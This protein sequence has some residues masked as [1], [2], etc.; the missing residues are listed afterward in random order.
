MISVD[1]RLVSEHSFPAALD[2]SYAVSKW[3]VNNA[4]E[5]FGTRSIVV[6]GESAGA[7]LA[8]MTLIEVRDFDVNEVQQFIGAN[9]TF[10]V[11][12]GVELITAR[13]SPFLR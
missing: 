13:K 5:E 12:T 2:D 6:G 7:Y 4:W 11:L 3:V 10:G 8:L 1:Y 9:P